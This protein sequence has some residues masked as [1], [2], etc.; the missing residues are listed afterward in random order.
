M[1]T[2]TLSL[3]VR[4]PG[5]VYRGHL[6]DKSPERMPQ[7]ARLHAALLNSA[8]R[9]IKAERARN[10]A[11]RPSEASVGALKWLEDNPPD[12]IEVPSHQWVDPNHK[13]FIYREV[14]SINNKHRTEERAIS[15]GVAVASHFG[16]LWEDVPV[17]VAKTVEDLCS[18]IAYIGEAESIAIVEPGKVT[19]T[20]ILDQNAS[21]FTRTGQGLDCAQPGRTQFLIDQFEKRAAVRSRKKEKTKWSELPISNPTPRTFVSPCRYR[22]AEARRSIG[23]WTDVVFLGL[24]GK[25]I[26]IERRVELAKTVHRALVASIGF[27]ASPM[28]TGKYPKSIR[29]RPSNHLAIHYLSELEAHH[30]GYNHGVVAILVPRDADELGLK[31]LA[32]AMKRLASNG[33]WSAVLGRREVTFDGRSCAAESFWPEVEAGKKRLWRSATAIVPDTRPVS[34]RRFGA[35][36]TLADAGLLSIAFTWKDELEFSG[37]HDHLYINGRNAAYGKGARVF[38]AKTTAFRPRQYAHTVPSDVT[39]HAWNGLID[40]GELSD[41]CTIAAIGQSRH[42]GG[43]LLVPEDITYEKYLELKGVKTHG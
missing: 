16:F 17:D 19:P 7:P 30:L 38:E 2:T 39:V 18:D 32:M 29:K 15:D 23:P 27:G 24:P 13:R 9:G 34:R 41:E 26:P 3:R 8:G 31:Q 43:G 40:L 22:K 4:F 6:P 1:E 21:P 37:K 12:G 5:G 10:G 36:W 11:L 42:M 25:D 20:L 35:P 28:I 14:S 33:L